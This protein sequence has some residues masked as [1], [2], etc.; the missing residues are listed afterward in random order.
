MSRLITPPPASSSQAVVFEKLRWNL[1]IFKVNFGYLTLK[2]YTKGERVLRFEAIAHH[3]KQL[4]CGRRLDKFGQI[5]DGLTGMVD[6]FTSMLD[7]VELAFVPD[8]ILDQLP[9]PS[10]LGATRT[11]GID[12]NIP[13]IRAALTT[14]QALAVAPQEFTVAHRYHVPERAARTIAALLTIRDKIIAPLAAGIRTPRRGGVPKARH[15]CPPRHHQGLLEPDAMQ[16]PRPILRRAGPSNGPGL[17]DNRR[18]LRWAKR[19]DCRFFSTTL[20]CQRRSRTDRP[21]A[22]TDGKSGV[23]VWPSQIT[24]PLLV[25]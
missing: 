22:A 18:R 25:R 15:L 13:R 20:R 9:R 21:G 2:A 24:V 11:G 8:G 17:S 5:I 23:Q 6:R 19:T 12:L 14:V 4:G 16:G 3:T 1:T 10:T 7:C